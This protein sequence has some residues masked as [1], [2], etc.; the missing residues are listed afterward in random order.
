MVYKHWW[1]MSWRACSCEEQRRDIPG[2]G[3]GVC[4]C[5]S[6]NWSP[7]IEAWSM[8]LGIPLLTETLS[9]HSSCRWKNKYLCSTL[10]LVPQ[11]CKAGR[12][13]NYQGVKWILRDL[14]VK[15]WT[16][17][18]RHFRKYLSGQPIRVLC[19]AVSKRSHTLDKQPFYFIYLFFNI[20]I[21]V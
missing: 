6:S 12:T 8:T 10:S 7:V 21:G 18:Q 2:W 16:K 15:E 14:I 11:H 4:V 19:W 17:H 1:C 3:C 9:S 13:E 5:R 20:F